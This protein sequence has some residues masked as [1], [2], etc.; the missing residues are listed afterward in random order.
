M[1]KITLVLFTLLVTLSMG[2]LSAQTCGNG[3][4]IAYLNAVGVAD[5]AAIIAAATSDIPP[6]NHHFTATPSSITSTGIHSVTIFLRNNGGHIQG[7]CTTNITVL[8]FGGLPPIAI[9]QDFTTQLD[10]TGNVTIS[11][12]DIDNGSNDPAGGTVT[13]SLD[14]T[15]FTCTDVGTPVLVTLTVTSDT[16]G[17]TATCT[18]TVTVEDNIA[19]TAV[20]QNITIQLDGAGNASIIAADIGGGSMDNCGSVTLSASQTAFTCA[21]L[22]PNN[23]TLTVDDGN[24]NSSTCVSVVTVEDAT[25]PTITCPGN[26]VGSVDASCN[27]TLPDYTALATPADNCPGVVVTQVP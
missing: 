21:D 11:P 16:T 5:E 17:N 9:C 4:G 25:N 7:S 10:A 27:F 24:G 2:Q 12:S 3:T 15:T 8:P 1:K 6:A 26:Q 20:C 23:V 22:G 13:L 14:Q 18:A 19:P